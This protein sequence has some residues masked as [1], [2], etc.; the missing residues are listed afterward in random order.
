MWW[1]CPPAEAQQNI[2]CRTDQLNTSHVDA[3]IKFNP[4]DEDDQFVKVIS[5][6]TVYVPLK[7]WEPARQL[8]FSAKSPEYQ[9][10]MGCL[11]R[12][13]GDQ[14]HGKKQKDRSHS[15]EWRT[16]EP[17]VTI[18]G[19]TVTVEYESFA[20]I[21]DHK[22]IRLGPWEI[23]GSGGDKWNVYLRPPTLDKIRWTSV[24]AKLND[25][26]FDDQSKK[27]SFIENHS[28]TWI[29]RPPSDIKFDVELPWQRSWVLNYD[30]SSWSS[31]GVAVWWVCASIVIALTAVPAQRAYT[32]PAL[33]MRGPTWWVALIGAWQ[34]ES[35][36]RTVLRWAA[37]SVAVAL[38]L[39]ALIKP[40]FFEPRW[41]ALIC[42][43]AGLTLVLLARPW[44]RG[45]ASQ[46][47]DA[48]VD[49]A[50]APDRAKRRQAQAVTVTA[51][52]VAAIG[53]LVVLSPGLFGLSRHLEREPQESITLGRIGLELMGLAT[54][55]LWLAAMVAWA[56]RFAREGGLV[57][58][59]WALKYD[60]APVRW[61]AAVGVLLG[62]ASV[63]LLWC[64]RTSTEL[65]WKRNN[66]LI[67]QS[68][69]S[70][71]KD[72]IKYINDQLGRFAFT[73]LLWIFSCSWLLAGIALISLLH[74]RVQAA[75]RTRAGHKREWFPL[76]PNR[77]ELVLTVV[78]FAFTV[79]LRG[80]SFV[81]VN[82]QYGVWF[83]LNICSLVMVLAVGRKRSTLKQLGQHFYNQK[84]DTAE[85]R[86]ELRDKAHEYRNLNHQTYLLDHG[87]ATDITNEELEDRLHK[88][89][90]WL[91]AGCDPRKNPPNQISV[92]D[93][94]LAWGPE[95]HWWSN[96]LRAARLAFA[97]GVPASAAL[98]YLNVQ[99][100]WNWI[101]ILYEP[102]R[103][104]EVVVSAI[105]YQVAWA[106][107]GFVLGALW[108]LLP[109]HRGPRRAWCLTIAYALPAGVVLLFIHLTDFIRL[110]NVGAEKLLLFSLLMLTILTL[111]SIW[112]DTATFSEERQFWPSRFTLLLSIYQVQGF[113][114]QVVLLITQVGAVVTTYRALVP[115]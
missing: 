67:D 47:S 109:G 86:Q 25:L 12:G 87:R 88:L 64:I 72:H 91:V 4:H 43:P 54:V 56:W 20:W 71:K 51:S 32:P 33:G 35:P 102:V 76:G 110:K 46:A 19:D 39:I 26:K 37:F 21:K 69:A 79:G 48:G 11:L 78:I 93:A 95:D 17:K 66:W 44:S 45:M 100:S 105:S 111:T 103:I 97:F 112:M 2:A 34:G 63:A 92:L 23:E 16:H 77:P 62:G 7:S 9:S 106:G 82:A 65:Q 27:S 115:K 70:V 18:T 24:T 52:A 3:T 90:L 94:A 84:L 30:G 49:E 85:H 73:D 50:T 5:N 31:A 8:A 42:I 41:Q 114:G 36:V 96:A 98:V 107:A 75:Q 13:Q 113:S 61:T 29:N 14:S 55:W 89:R 59:R 53:L 28:L 81:G 101:R 40:Q 57:S 104:P 83:L 68:S 10:A 6:M 58:E 15:Q 1:G 108:R 22:P 74:F 80:A 99:G 38:T 60:K